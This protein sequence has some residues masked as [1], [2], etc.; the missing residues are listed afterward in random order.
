MDLDLGPINILICWQSI[1]LALCVATATHGVKTVIDLRIEGGKIAR[2]EMLVVNRLVLPA[3]PIILGS[4]AAMFIPI[5]PDALTQYITEHHIEH[6]KRLITLAAYG[7]CVGQFADYVWHRFSGIKDDL[8][9]RQAAN[10]AAKPADPAAPP[11]ADPPAPP[12][13]APPAAPPAPGA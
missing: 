7:S 2:Q 13:A 1:L 10:E 4:L 3:T 12:P 9:K 5:L 11:P 8:Q 6:G